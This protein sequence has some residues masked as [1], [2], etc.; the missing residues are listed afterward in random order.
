MVFADRGLGKTWFSLTIAIAVTRGLPIGPWKTVNPVGCLYLDGEMAREDLQ[1]RLRQLTAGLPAAQ[2]PFNILSSEDLK[3][4]NEPAI[5]LVDENCRKNILSDLKY[6]K[7]IQLLIVD[8][9]SCLAPRIS[10]NSKIPWDDVNQW[11]LELRAIDVAVILVHH[12][13]KTG[14][15]RGTSAHTRTISILP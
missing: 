4:H 2:A 7:S 9:I 14:T 3:A 11:L 1:S 12:T 6:D 5:D 13:G 8:N 15:Q 10:E